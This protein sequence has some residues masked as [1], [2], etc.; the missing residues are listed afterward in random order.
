MIDSTKCLT[1]HRREISR[2]QAALPSHAAWR[3]RDDSGVLYNEIVRPLRIVLVEDND[4]IRDMLEAMLAN[5]GH[6]VSTAKDG[7]S[8]LA[9]IL[10]DWPDAAIVDIGLPGFDGHELARSIR[11]AQSSR[12]PVRLLALSGWGRLT[13]REAALAAGFDA[14]LTKPAKASAVIEALYGD[15]DF[16]SMKDESR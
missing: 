2:R 13:D 16:P 7:P 9:L 12:P 3:W 15:A 11:A 4:D 5:D 1:D 10:A 14:H 8:G 6:H